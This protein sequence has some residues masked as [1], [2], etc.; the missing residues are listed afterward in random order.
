LASPLRARGRTARAAGRVDDE[1]I[2]A[3]AVD[4]TLTTPPSTGTRAGA[5]GHVAARR[6]EVDAEVARYL[7]ATSTVVGSLARETGT[8]RSR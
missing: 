4:Q 8:P 2:G 6:G 5:V 7:R 3:R 1:Q